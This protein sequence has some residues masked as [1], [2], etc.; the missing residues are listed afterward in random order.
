MT[1]PYELMLDCKEKGGLAEIPAPK[2]CVCLLS[3]LRTEMA[4]RTIRGLAENLDYPKELVSFYVGDDGSPSEHMDAI[5]AEIKNNGFELAG[6][7]NEKSRPG[8]P[9]CGLGWNKALRQGHNHADI[10]LWMEDDWVLERPL[11]IRPY[12]RLL[13]EREDVGIVRLSGLPDG[14]DLRVQTHNGIHYL[15]CLRS[16][17]MAYSGNPHLRHVRFSEYY[18]TFGI[19]LTPGDLEIAYDEKFRRST[20]GPN[21][22]RPADISAWGIFGHIGRERTW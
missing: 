22:W 15:E 2:I 11:D 21:I 6:Y 8:T 16:T 3:Y 10:I 9:F 4:L 18:G 5:L 20:G 19:N 13:L 17:R 12:V 7:H 14:L 1:E